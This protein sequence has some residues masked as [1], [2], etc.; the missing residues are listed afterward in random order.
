MQRTRVLFLTPM[1]DSLQLPVIPVLENAESQTT[2]GQVA[3]SWRERDRDR[4]TEKQSQTAI[5]TKRQREAETDKEIETERQRQ[6]NR[7]RQK[8]D[9]II[10]KTILMPAIIRQI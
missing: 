9:T 3:R 6:S 2:M 8:R 4:E 5:E 10:F 7:Q 1:L